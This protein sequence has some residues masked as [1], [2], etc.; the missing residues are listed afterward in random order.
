ML[1][2]GNKEYKSTNPAWEKKF[3]ATTK[4][5]MYLFISE[6]YDVSEVNPFKIKHNQ[7]TSEHRIS[8]LFL[9]GMLV[10]FLNCLIVAAILVLVNWRPHLFITAHLGLPLITGHTPLWRHSTYKYPF[11]E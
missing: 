10:L 1:W 8:S 7:N 6:Y 3:R 2:L 5:Y 4:Y 9:K 11:T